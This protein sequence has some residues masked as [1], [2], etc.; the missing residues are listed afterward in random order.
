MPRVGTQLLTV[1]AAW[2]APSRTRT[3]MQC[4]G[5]SSHVPHKSSRSGSRHLH[6]GHRLANKREP[7]RLVPEQKPSPRF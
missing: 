1:F 4:R 2:S 3:G 7:A 5:M 6:A